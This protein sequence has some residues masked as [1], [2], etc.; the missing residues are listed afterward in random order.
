MIGP[1]SKATDLLWIHRP[2][3]STEWNP[4][5]FQTSS[6]VIQETGKLGKHQALVVLIKDLEVFHQFLDFGRLDRG[7]MLVWL[8]PLGRVG[9]QLEQRVGVDVVTAQGAGIWAG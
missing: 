5:L 1:Q 2:I 4:L 6:D 9:G 8:F 7:H 3:E